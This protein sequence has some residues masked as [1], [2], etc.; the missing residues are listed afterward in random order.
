MSKYINA[1]ELDNL[2]DCIINSTEE[3]IMFGVDQAVIED[4]DPIG[5]IMDIIRAVENNTNYC[6]EAILF[7]CP[8]PDCGRTHVNLHFYIPEEE[9]EG[10]EE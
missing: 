8:N 10:E 2:I 6:G 4:S 9:E 7:R 3:E 5:D 1:A